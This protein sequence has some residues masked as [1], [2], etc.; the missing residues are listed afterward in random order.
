MLRLSNFADYGVVVMTA[1][2]RARNLGG[3]ERLS[4]G[5]VAEASGIP[6]ATVAKLMGHL[7]RAGLLVSQRG[8]DGGFGLARP[9]ESI[10]L[11]E[12]V[13]AIDGPI[14]LTHCSQPTAGCGLADGCSV[15]PHW[16]P[17]NRAVRAALSGV[18]LADLAAAPAEL[19]A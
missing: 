14:G 11:A 5:R 10:S 19:C 6:P 15:R 17:V 8:V 9:A 3:V 13:E 1:A 12:I 4:A 18:S 2:A 16:E 7:G